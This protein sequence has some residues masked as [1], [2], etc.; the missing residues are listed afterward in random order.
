M[1]NIDEERFRGAVRVLVSQ[2]RY[3]DHGLLCNQLGV[4]YT[5]SGFTDRQTNWRKQEVE[6]A[7]YDFEAS[8][9]ARR[10]VKKARQL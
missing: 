7:G 10:L 9:Q 1:R 4:G 5:H 8:K 6:T 2:G 3:P